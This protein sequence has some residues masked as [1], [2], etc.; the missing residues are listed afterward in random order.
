MHAVICG[1]GIAGLAT[2]ISLQRHGWSVTLVEHAVSLRDGGYMIDFFGPGYDAAER[3][4]ILDDLRERAHEV[5]R[6][7][8]V[9]EHGRA[10]ARLRYDRMRDALD[11]RLFSLLRGDVERS[12]REAL[13]A[14]V[15]LRFGTT[16]TGVTQH[17]GGVT[18]ELGDER[19]EADLLVGADG[20]HSGVR[21][22]VFGPEERFLR[23]L[24][25][26]TAAWFFRS[27]EVHDAIADRF[28]MMSVPGRMAGVYEVEPGLFATFFVFEEQSTAM[29]GDPLAA[30]RER[31]GDLGGFVP[32]MLAAD[33][34]DD[35]YYDVVA[36]VEAPA[37]HDGR[38]VL[39]GDSAY[40]VSLVA[41]QGA[42]LALSG[43]V[44]LGEALDA[45]S[46]AGDPAGIEAALGAFEARV[47]PSVAEKQAAGRKTAKWFVPATPLQIALRNLAMRVVDLPGMGR[48]VSPAIGVDAKGFAPATR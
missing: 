29:P 32:A 11:G 38:V 1:A 14:D 47:R 16:V 2:A 33:P 12:L 15:E 21:R 40:A 9:D 24:G 27:D 19:V 34:V 41:G 7:E 35:V 37:W 18:V 46:L 6:V 22:E 31:F 8:W 42:S 43:G 48:L 23:P 45:E 28:V 10:H 20:I 36:Q 3:I 44:A 13:P 17:D 25:L 5:D 39:I 30:L 26:H 4:G